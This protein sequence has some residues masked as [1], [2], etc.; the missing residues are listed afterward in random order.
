MTNPDELP[1]WSCPMCQ[2]LNAGWETEC[3]HCALSEFENRFRELCKATSV[4]M[5]APISNGRAKVE[6][7]FKT[8]QEAHLAHLFLLSIL[9]V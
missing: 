3:N 9:S 1:S 8:E 7:L 5:V 6:M 2:H 4:Y